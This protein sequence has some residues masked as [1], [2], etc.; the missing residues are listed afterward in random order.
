M[1]NYAV[2]FRPAGRASRSAR[3]QLYS[4]GR[5][6]GMASVAATQRSRSRVLGLVQHDVLRQRARPGPPATRRRC[7]RTVP[8][9]GECRRPAAAGARQARSGHRLLVP[10]VRA[11]RARLERP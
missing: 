9:S 8:T 6:G 1:H 7:G 11:K 3:G 10:R 5:R 2:L 4:D